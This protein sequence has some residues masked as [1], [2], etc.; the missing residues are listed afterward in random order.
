MKSFIMSLFLLTSAGG[1]LLGIFVAPWAKDPYL[2][3]MYVGFSIMCFGTGV[4]FW[5]LFRGY[6][7]P[8]EEG[9]AL[10]NLDG[11]RLD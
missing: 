2:T 7:R 6:D 5:W 1:S 4:V 3:W 9:L 11:D 8:K 10:R